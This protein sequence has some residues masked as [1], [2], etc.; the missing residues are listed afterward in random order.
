MQ[1]THDNIQDSCDDIDVEISG[2]NQVR[3]SRTS[4]GLKSEDPPEN[5]FA[6][7]KD[8]ELDDDL[9]REVSDDDIEDDQVKMTEK[10]PIR[11]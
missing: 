7:K 6:M 3:N 8:D 11:V 9:V 10:E 2:E 4:G 5:M 1:I